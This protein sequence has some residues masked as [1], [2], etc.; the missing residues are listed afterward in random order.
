MTKV[1]SLA[2]RFAAGLVAAQLAFGAVSVSA[3]MT[4]A[5]AAAATVLDQ[6]GAWQGFTNVSNG[7][8]VYG[9]LTKLNKGGT[10]AFVVKDDTLSL[11]LSDPTWTLT[12]GREL[13]VKLTVDG[14]VFTGTAIV[15]AA[16]SSRCRKSTPG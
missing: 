5:P 2:R 4:A 6:Q 13:P 12:V 1:A 9:A 3:V 11:L 15:A 10:A 7:K 8:P 16:T 14:A